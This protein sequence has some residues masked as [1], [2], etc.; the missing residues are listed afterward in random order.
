MKKKVL[1]LL[2][3][4]AFIYNV[5]A[6]LVDHC[7]IRENSCNSNEVAIMSASNYTNAHV[8]LNPDFY[9]WKVCCTGTDL[10]PSIIDSCQN[11][12][13]CALGTGDFPCPVFGTTKEDNAH[14]SFFKLDKYEKCL[15]L[16]DVDKYTGFGGSIVSSL[17]ECQINEGEFCLFSLNGT[18]NVTTFGG[19]TT[20]LD[21]ANAHI[22]PC[23][24]PGAYNNIACTKL[25]EP[26]SFAATWYELYNFHPLGIDGDVCATNLDC[27]NRFGGTC[28]TEIT[29][30]NAC[31]C[32]FPGPNDFGYIKTI[33]GV[34]TGVN[35]QGLGQR[36]DTI[37]YYDENDVNYLNETSLA[38]CYSFEESEPG[39]G[40]ISILIVLFL[41]IMFYLDR[42]KFKYLQK[43][44]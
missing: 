3:F 8:S 4:F 17:N 44:S 32:V 19:S 34:C 26:C 2:M 11:V 25:A 7:E 33:Q 21:N 38:V 27:S 36:N 24:G 1:F 14:T 23:E 30:V 16:S 40:L 43:G 28:D 10:N 37:L 35:D 22:G 12:E 13:A 29:S 20:L 39:F 15:S 41:L 42:E 5:N 9:D 31:T 18:L 6:T